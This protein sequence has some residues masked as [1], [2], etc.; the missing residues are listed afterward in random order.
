MSVLTQLRA[1][2]NGAA[3]ARPEALQDPALASAILMIEVARA[4][5]AD[6]SEEREALNAALAKQFGMSDQE[7]ANIITAAEQQAD[8]QVS[9]H[10]VIDSINQQL[11]AREK[12]SLME[13]LW[14]I[15]FA[16]GELHQ[17]EEHFIRRTA[18]LIHVPHREFIRS[19]L[20]AQ[21]SR[22]LN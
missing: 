14:H 2:L 21:Q 12:F 10:R 11:S 15:A 13:S 3:D 22:K 7:L 17:W 5:Y 18:D 8:S 4:D 20:Q 1:I 9:L 6:A 16:D 19:K